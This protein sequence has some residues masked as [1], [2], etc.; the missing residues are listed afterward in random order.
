MFNLLKISVSKIFVY[1]YASI[2]VLSLVIFACVSLFLYK[3][4]YQT[5]TS[6]AEVLVLRR[7]VAIEDID[8]NKFEEI[9]KKIELKTEAR[10]AGYLVNFR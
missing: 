3:N 5:I 9:V 6:S 8:M 2:A 1:F 10:Q 7:E 4:F